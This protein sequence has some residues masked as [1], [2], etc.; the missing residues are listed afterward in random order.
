M[1]E[2]TLRGRDTTG[3]Q[4]SVFS[5]YGRRI[6]LN[7]GAAPHFDNTTKKQPLR[8]HCF[9]WPKCLGGNKFIDFDVE[10]FHSL[11]VGKAGGNY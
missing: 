4:P 1:G 7:R 8:G 11:W 6:C 2:Q 3:G 10:A 9:R 5:L